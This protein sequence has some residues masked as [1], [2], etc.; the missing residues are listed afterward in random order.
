MA[1]RTTETSVVW[2]DDRQQQLRLFAQRAVAMLAVIMKDKNAHDMT[3]LRAAKLILDLA[4]GRPR[5]DC[6]TCVLQ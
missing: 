4:W 6:V 1:P 3:R 2:E 5:A